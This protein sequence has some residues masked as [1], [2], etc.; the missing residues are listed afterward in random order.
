MLLKEKEKWKKSYCIPS[1]FMLLLYHRIIERVFMVA[2]CL[3]SVCIYT[4]I[5]FTADGPLTSKHACKCYFHICLNSLASFGQCCLTWLLSDFFSLAI[6]LIC[7]MKCLNCFQIMFLPTVAL[8]HSTSVK[9][10]WR[11]R[12]KKGSWTS[13]TSLLSYRLSLQLLLLT[14][15][16]SNNYRCTY[17]VVD[18]RP[19]QHIV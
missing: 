1:V 10:I 5:Y 8:P 9:S 3:F 15:L 6:I 19:G 2:A 12:I 16:S 17:Q 18:V 7:V 13:L 11:R 4:V 14:C